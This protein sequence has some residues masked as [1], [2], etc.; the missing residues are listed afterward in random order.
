[1][2]CSQ[3]G[4]ARW[5]PASGALCAFMISASLLAVPV[6][7]QNGPAAVLDEDN[8]L[9]LDF[10]LERQRLAS[11]VTAYHAAGATFLS[12]TETAS[13]LGFPIGVDAAA[14]TASGWLISEDRRFA[15]DLGQDTVEIAGRRERLAAQD[16]V[17][18]GNDI[19]VNVDALTRWF[20][21]DFKLQRGALTMEV[22]P[23]EQLPVQ[24]QAARRQSGREN[25]TV[26]PAV[27]PPIDTPYRL[28]G[29]PAADIGLGYSI[30][31]D[32]NSERADTG[33]S[34]S[35][36]LSG[37]VAWMDARLYLSGNRNDA[38]S[39]A[40]FSLSRDQLGMPLGLRYVEIGDIVPALVPGL[41]NT[42]NVERGVLLQG[43][44]SV[45]GRDDLIDN[46]LIN[47]SGDALQGW[48]VELFQ[49]GMRVG[50]QTVGADGRY[51]F[52]NIEPLGGENEF[53]LVFYGPA[54]E[55][56]TERVTRYSGLS[57]DLPGSVRYQLSVSQK[58]RQLYEGED[59]YRPDL[60]DPGSTRVA[61]GME[62]RVL[63][64]LALRGSWTS[65]MVNGERHNYTSMG[66]R[67]GLGA[68]TLGVDATRTPSG[69]TRW[70]ASLQAPADMRVLG[71]DARFTHTHYAQSEIEEA[72]LV[73]EDGDGEVDDTVRLRSRTGL[74]LSRRFG[75]TSTRF[76]VFHNREY[77]RN[78]TE[79]SAGF[80]RQLG[81]GSFGNTLSYFRYGEDRSGVRAD[82][83][84][85]GSLFFST[86]F[87]PL[88]LRGG[89][90]YDLAP[91]ARVNQY[92]LDSSLSVAKDLSMAF[93]LTHTPRTE[94]RGSLTRYAAGF[95]W[96]LPQVTLSPRLIYDSDGT[97]SG[98]V[99]A[100]FS[101]APRPDASGMM[102]SGRSFA[103]SGA[104]AA[105]AFIDHDG[106]GTYTEGDEPLP[107]VVVRAPQGYQN[108][109]TDSDG[110]AVLTSLPARRATDV[111]VD[112][113]SL[114]GVGMVSTHA[115]N[116]VRPRP[117]A[118][119]M[120]EF[121]VVPTGTIEGHVHELRYGLKGAL[122]GALVELRDQSGEAVLF[123]T[124]TTDG[125]YVFDQV[126][127]GD[128]TVAVG[129][130]HR[131]RMQGEPRAVMA[132]KGGAVTGVDL[133]VRGAA[134]NG[135][136]SAPRSVLPPVAPATPAAAAP[137][138]RPAGAT[139]APAVTAPPAPRAAPAA[140]A[141]L[142]GQPAM[143]QPGRDGKVVQLGAFADSQ[144][145]QRHL[146]E[147]VASGH[148]D[149]ARA[150]LVVADRGAQGRFY[151][152]LLSPASGTAA[153]LCAALKA[154]GISCIT[155]AP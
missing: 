100:T 2:G 105:R 48:D 101:L 129:G 104:V 98:F 115:G 119:A 102:V 96:Q 103:S 54:G 70:D 141:G 128:Y 99:Y 132:G 73:D 56:R 87:Y 121:P 147:L 40:R 86:R 95:N 7:A 61:A 66:M 32:R 38:L 27:L 68:A 43:G 60:S 81:S 19:F 92:F 144:R 58:N 97:Y 82:D 3:R 145:A 12:L 47:I 4:R 152:V 65:Q 133:L 41:N 89:V 78:S 13:A 71:F 109:T 76:A 1:M 143:L 67:A 80:T 53:E 74:L 118:V 134:D 11:S 26:G 10:V 125:Y 90:N 17:R 30:R 9:L 35:A 72:E 93:T 138:A 136:G 69:R 91:E 139:P 110:V 29:A 120:I 108:A 146:D 20:P 111:V 137:V 22:V 52:R 94:S 37:D 14:G 142:G 122:A 55:R 79:V 126:P 135:G 5:R 113:D 150:G 42:G 46:D 16:A 28:L 127:Y 84:A 8:L 31:R 51:N 117:T 130:A 106:S 140:S 123:R 24:A 85:N 107:G 39:N 88:S 59:V 83:R 116:S 131:D 112:P 18:H 154:R 151:R 36:L 153:A 64:K 62:V 155:A 149:A 21:V 114:P 63:P 124:T 77:D 34:Y 148:I 6:Y 75:A 50:F 15:L 45:T 49:N 25:A 23:R 44:G 57:P 33:L